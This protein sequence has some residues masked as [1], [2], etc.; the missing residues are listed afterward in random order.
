[1]K[2]ILK[3]GDMRTIEAHLEAAYPKEGAGLMLGRA[4][5]DT[6]TIEALLP[7]INKREIE[8]QHNR[9]ELSPNDFMQ[10]ELAAAKRGLDLV[11]VFHSHPD[12]PNQPSDFD[13]EH[14]LPNFSYLITTVEAGEAKAT[15]AWRL[16]EDRHAF[17]EDILETVP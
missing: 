16:R 17:E 10:A 8:A 13:R 11:G 2:I 3:S 7:V 12:H 4:N 15:R 9:Y 14:A 5:G 1:M 6:V